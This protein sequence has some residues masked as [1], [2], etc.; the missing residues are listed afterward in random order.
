M[1]RR[2]GEPDRRG[3]ARNRRA[4]KAYLLAA[5]GNGVQCPCIW[6][7]TTLTFATL[8]QDRLVA[9]GPYRRDNLV[10]SCGRC[11]IARR[12]L[13]IPDGCQYGP[14]GSETAADLGLPPVPPRASTDVRAVARRAC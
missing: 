13:D 5:F 14:V 7:G 6:C 10:P 12:L 11:N 1:C 8:Q 3:S 2:C 9:G 4:R